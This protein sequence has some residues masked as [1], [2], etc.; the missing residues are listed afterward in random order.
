M[1]LLGRLICLV[2]G[3]VPVHDGHVTSEVFPFGL[4]PDFVKLWCARC[5]ETVHMINDIGLKEN[6]Q[7]W[8]LS[9]RARKGIMVHRL[10]GDFGSWYQFQA[11]GEIEGLMKT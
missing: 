1:K 5:G 11:M 8:Q 10:L 7:R 4:A 9:E 2:K 6:V 3:H